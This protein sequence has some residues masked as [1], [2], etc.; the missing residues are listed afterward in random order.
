[1]RPHRAIVVFVSSPL[2]RHLDD[3]PRILRRAFANSSPPSTP[4]RAKIETPAPNYNK[5]TAVTVAATGACEPFAPL[6]A[7]LTWPLCCLAAADLP[8]AA[9]GHKNPVAVHSQ[10][11][12]VHRS[13]VRQ[14][15]LP[16]LL[17][18]V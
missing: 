13:K 17:A 10:A 11:P 1:M 15:P 14:A 2:C 9:V 6:L 8:S 4:G 12:K 3:A 5:R 7:L 16:S 18:A